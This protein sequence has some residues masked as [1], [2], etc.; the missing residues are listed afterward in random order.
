MSTESEA[1]DPDAQSCP[2]RRLQFEA[3]IHSDGFDHGEQHASKACGAA[4]RCLLPHAK[5]DELRVMGRITD[6]DDDVLTP[7]RHISHR[8]PRG[9][10][11]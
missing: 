7:I 1:R 10:G 2:N 8:S 4:T 11:R 3:R 6:R 9:A 5:R